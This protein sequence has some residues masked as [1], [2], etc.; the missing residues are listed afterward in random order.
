MAFVKGQSGNP[1]GRP[2]VDVSLVEL[3]KSKTADAINTLA[4]IM[5]DKGASP[6]AR[7]S[8]SS[9]ILDRGHGK[10][11][12]FS[13]GDVD[14]FRR[15]VE[16]TDDEL[17]ADIAKSRAIIEGSWDGTVPAEGGSQLTH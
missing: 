10:A 14:Q 4:E 15:A 13:T 17:A 8:A 9:E 16:M 11:P 1:S 12:A 7:V 6:S 5:M 3:A 2:K